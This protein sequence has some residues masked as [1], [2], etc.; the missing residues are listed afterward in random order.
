ME[1]PISENRPLPEL[2]PEEHNWAA[3]FAAYSKG[4]TFA[5]IADTFDVAERM[6]RH[7]A[8]EQRWAELIVD[9]KQLPDKIAESSKSLARLENNR[10]KN[11]AVFEGLREDLVGMLGQLAKGT[12]KVKRKMQTKLEVVDVEEE[13]SIRDRVLLAQAA[14]LVAEGTYRALGDYSAIEG[15]KSR[16]DAGGLSGGITILLPSFVHQA[17]VRGV[18]PQADAEVIDLRGP[19]S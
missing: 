18:G 11:L 19:D 5:E 10:E 9:F 17:E 6:V 14:K 4:T 2:R 12:L 3:M 13:P 7:K 15:E 8:T 16:K 1:N